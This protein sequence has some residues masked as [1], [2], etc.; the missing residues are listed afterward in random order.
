MNKQLV[1]YRTALGIGLACI[2]QISIPSVYAQQVRDIREV[3]ADLTVPKMVKE[4]PAAVSELHKLIRIMPRQMFTTASICRLTG[5]PE[6]SIRLFLS[7]PEMGHTGASMEMN[8]Q[9]K[10]T[11]AVWVMESLVE[12]DL[13]GC[14]CPI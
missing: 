3:K 1:C 12:K 9:V 4:K 7:M 5:N 2:L 10:L 14:A 11:T 6:S 13:F 8:A